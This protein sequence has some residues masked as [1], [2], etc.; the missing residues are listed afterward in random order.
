MKTRVCLLLLAA[1]SALSGFRQVSSE[2]LAKEVVRR[3]DGHLAAEEHAELYRYARASQNGDVQEGSMLILFR[4]GDNE[5][6]GVFRLLPDDDNAGV[7][8][9]SRQR[10]G[11]L[12]ELS[13]YD[14][15]E[16][17]GGRVAPEGLRRKLGDTDWFFEG[18]FDDDKNPWNYRK[19]DKLLFRGQT[20]DV[21]EARYSD[22]RFQEVCGYDF[23]RILIRQGDGQPLSSEFYDQDGE[24]VYVIDLLN[25]KTFEYDG[26]AHT[27]IKQLLLTDLQAGSCTILTRTASSWQPEL[28]ADIYTLDFADDWDEETDA[29]VQAKLQPVN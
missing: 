1:G 25:H 21:I 2:D 17:A 24:L 29:L 16:Q 15:N 23:R 28:P 14:R 11:E 9:I 22:P 7:T 4:Y 6:N 27:R 3:M 5:V 26:D 18:I 20:A 10:P 13:H 19:T 12:P 8:L